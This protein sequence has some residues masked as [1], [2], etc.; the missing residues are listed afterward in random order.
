MVILSIQKNNL[1]YANNTFTGSSKG[2]PFA[3]TYEVKNDKTEIK[4]EF[5]F[6]H[7]TGSEWDPK[8]I[9]VYKSKCGEYELHMLNDDVTPETA[10]NYLTAKLNNA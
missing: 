6:S 3:T 9:W 4:V 5:L 10:E 2:I 1:K 8:T 7:S